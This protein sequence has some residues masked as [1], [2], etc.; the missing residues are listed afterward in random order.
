MTFEQFKDFCIKTEYLTKKGITKYG[1][2]IDREDE[3]GGYT[4]GNIQLLT[5]TENVKK[6]YSFDAENRRHRAITI[7]EV[8]KIEDDLPF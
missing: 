8:E 7:N 3:N 1:Y 2:G 4:I 5:N 6:K